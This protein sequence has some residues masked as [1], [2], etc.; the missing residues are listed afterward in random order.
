MNA[1]ADIL[2]PIDLW[3]QPSTLVFAIGNSGRQD[4][5]LGW[6]LGER[7]QAD[8]RFPGTVAFR[9]QLQVEDAELLA[10]Y[11]RILF[12]DASKEELPEGIAWSRAEPAGQVAFSTHALSPGTVLQLAKELYGASPAAWILA[13]AGKEWELEIGLS[14]SARKHLEHAWRSLARPLD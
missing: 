5:G 12:V 8:T 13:M 10:G 3:T 1:T 14:P 7:L 6:A 4:D 9:Y 2:A 11:Q